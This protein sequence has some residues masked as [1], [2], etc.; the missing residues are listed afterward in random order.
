MI[1]RAGEENGLTE[2]GTADKIITLLNKYHLPVSDGAPLNAV[3]TAAGADKKRSADGFNL[4]LLRRIG[5]S[6]VYPVKNRDFSVF[7]DG[8]SRL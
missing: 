2:K 1:A 6:M 7:F 3:L 8:G 5:D 4:V